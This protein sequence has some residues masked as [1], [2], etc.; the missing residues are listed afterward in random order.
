MRRQAVARSSS[1][2]L[3]GSVAEKRREKTE[4]RTADSSRGTRRATARIA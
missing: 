1:D 4:G 2:A 3:S